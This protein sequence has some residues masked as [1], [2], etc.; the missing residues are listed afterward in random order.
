MSMLE[1]LRNG[2]N[3]WDQYLLV[4]IVLLV[5]CFTVSFHKK[6]KIKK[7]IRD[8]AN[9]ATEM[10]PEE[11]FRMRNF[12]LD[13]RKSYA[14]TLNFAGVYILYNK[15]KH[16]YYVGQSKQVLDR[17]NAHFTGHGNGDV[18][19]DYKCG[20]TFSIRTI[21]LEGSGCKTLNELERNAI[22]TYDAYRN[23]YNKTR[24]NK[25]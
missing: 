24:G 23:G 10:S 15:T 1:S 25:G 6:R 4:C 17:V 9:N 12:S 8:L 19:A 14:K 21:K 3:V 11:F 13:G 20:N 7:Q 18:Y 22:M 16:L 5:V 2:I